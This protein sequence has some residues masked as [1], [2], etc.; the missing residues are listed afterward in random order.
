MSELLQ[1]LKE[2]RNEFA[3]IGLTVT[4]AE[5][6]DASR[7][8]QSTCQYIKIPTCIAHRLK[9]T[10]ILMHDDI[11]Q[12]LRGGKRVKVEALFIKSGNRKQG[13]SSRRSSP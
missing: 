8:L 3:C 4:N 11:R 13:A 12:E 2:L 6:V 7:F 1:Q 10:V 5:G 9:L